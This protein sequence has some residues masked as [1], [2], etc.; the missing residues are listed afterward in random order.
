VFSFL[1]IGWVVMSGKEATA[2]IKIN[3][4]LKES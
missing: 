2:R 3:D 4:L 1:V